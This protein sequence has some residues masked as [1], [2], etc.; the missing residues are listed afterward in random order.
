[1][2]THLSQLLMN[3]QA[4]SG[5]VGLIAQIPAN[6][7]PEHVYNLRNT[8]LARAGAS[9]SDEAATIA[10]VKA[11]ISCRLPKVFEFKADA[12]MPCDIPHSGLTWAVKAEIGQ[13]VRRGVAEHYIDS[14]R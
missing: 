3:L 10:A 11:T 9:A 7:L 13:W 4:M 1:M 5:D 8:L 12:V 2:F 14:N 6:R